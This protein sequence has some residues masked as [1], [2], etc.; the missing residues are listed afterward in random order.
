[1]VPTVVQR[2]PGLI[3]G[4]V[5]ASGLALLQVLIGG[6]GLLFPLPGYALLCIAALLAVWMVGRSR[7]PADSF[8]LYATAIFCGYVGLRAIVSPGY[9]ARADVLSVAGAL[10]V[11]GITTTVLTSSK[12]RLAAVLT[13][14]GVALVHVLIGAV[15]FSRG[16]NFMLIPFLQRADYGQ[17]ASGFY[18][19]PN[20]LAGLLEVVGIFGIALTCWGRLP[21]WAK[22]LIGYVTGLCYAGLALTGSRGGY[23]SVLG[24]FVAFAIVSVII[25]RAAYPGR[26]LK[27]SAFGAGALV[28]VALFGTLLIQGSTFLSSRAGSI[29]D[30]KNVRMDLWQASIHQWHL[31]PIFG[32]GAGTYRFYGRQF[33]TEQMQNDPVD[34]HNDYL[35]LLCEYGLFGVAAFLVFFSAHAR[36]GWAC[37]SRQMTSAQ[38]GGGLLSNRRAL[39]I[40]ALAAIAAY[41]VHSGFDFNLHVPANAML[42]AFVFGLIAH[43]TES[44]RPETSR[45]VLGHY[46]LWATAG[47][48][49]ILL[50]LCVRFF[51]AEYYMERARAALRDEDPGASI[52][53][54]N[55]ALQYDRRNPELYF[56]LGRALMASSRGVDAADDRVQRAEGAVDAFHRAH[57]LAPLDSGYALSLAFA[58]DELAR[59]ED[60]ER[61]YAVARARDPRSQAVSQ[62]YQAHLESREKSASG[63]AGSL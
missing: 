22:L 45:D 21:V 62:L 61:M 47:V 19:C 52:L 26:W 37:V 18:V 43:P 39:C 42:L 30:R 27:F 57:S 15:Q 20:H 44:H 2:R 58:Y 41:V 28:A 31:Q 38:R 51:P 7:T 12:A 34:V 11:Y 23:L 29:A 9:F 14:L 16:D 13:L 50:V 55:K 4:L 6:R 36:Q 40:G 5:F 48:A 63:P 46:P 33:R 56:Y 49:A 3:V 17:R 54:A 53:Y 32:T 24:S 60:A 59:F 1:M 35:H 10:V 25:L 8:C